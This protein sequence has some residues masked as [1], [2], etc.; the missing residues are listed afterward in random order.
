MEISDLKNMT[1]TEVKQVATDLGV[2]FHHKNSAETVIKK[3]EAALEGKA[4]DEI[5]DEDGAEGEDAESEGDFNPD[6]LTDDAPVEEQPKTGKPIEVEKVEDP[7]PTAQQAY[8]PHASTSKE[9]ATVA[10][11]KKALEPFLRRGLEI[12]QMTENYWHIRAGKKEAAGNMKMPL[13]TLF[14][15]AS[16]LFTATKIASDTGAAV[17]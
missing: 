12:V 13:S 10:T 5:K 11:A 3:I 15:E 1:E 6:F 8:Q 2:E 9:M 16:L 4:G 7:R 17:R 14:Q